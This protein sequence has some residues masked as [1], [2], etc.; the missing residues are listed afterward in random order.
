MLKKLY[1]I[2]ILVCIFW[3]VFYGSSSEEGVLGFFGLVVLIIV[4][5]LRLTKSKKKSSADRWY[6]ERHAEIQLDQIDYKTNMEVYRIMMKQAEDLKRE[7][8]SLSGYKRNDMLKKADELE[9]EAGKH[10]RSII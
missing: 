7:A 8:R 1:W 9:R 6:E 5:L 3:V 2:G 10:Y 4:P